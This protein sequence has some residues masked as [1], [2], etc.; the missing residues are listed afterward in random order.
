MNSSIFYVGCIYPQKIPHRA[1][2]SLEN[3]K[4]ATDFT[5]L[6]SVQSVAA[7]QSN[8]LQLSTL[9]ILLFPVRVDENHPF[10]HFFFYQL[11]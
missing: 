11:L 2:C 1:W 7:L 3:K 4:A 5:K 10:P 6:I 9:E 8:Y